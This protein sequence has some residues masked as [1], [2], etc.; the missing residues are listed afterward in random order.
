[1]RGGRWGFVVERECRRYLG[2]GLASL[3]GVT[4]GGVFGLLAF[5]VLTPA[6]RSGLAAALRAL[7]AG[8]ARG[9]MPAG[10]FAAALVANL[11]SLGLV[12]L[13]GLSVVGVPLVLAALFLRGFVVGFSLGV[14]WG[15]RTE[16][17]IGWLLGAVAV[18]NLLWVPALVVTGALALAFSWW[19]VKGRQL[20]SQGGL[21]AEFARYTTG[22]LVM[23]LVAVAATG[24]EVFLA[25]TV[26]HWVLRA[27]P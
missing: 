6:E 13:L 22:A 19:L 21:F 1:M 17:G 27:T 25:P 16:A 7:L 3:G 5:S 9:V 2:F 24:W 18:Q 14:L 26:L 11:K 8:L 15:D 12:Y 20:S 4:L 23:A 10:A